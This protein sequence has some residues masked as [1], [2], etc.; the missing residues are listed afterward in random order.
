MKSYRAANRQVLVKVHKKPKVRFKS[1]LELER[2]EKRFVYEIG[3]VLNQGEKV[4]EE[5]EGSFVIYNKFRALTLEE[6]IRVVPYKYIL[7]QS[8]NL[9]ELHINE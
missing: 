7:L 6:D 9:D 5:L 1:G 4:I 8:D 2:R 3:E